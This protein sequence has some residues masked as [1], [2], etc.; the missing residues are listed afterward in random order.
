MILLSEHLRLLVLAGNWQVLRHSFLG[1]LI[2]RALQEGALVVELYLGL[3][4]G[5]WLVILGVVG[6]VES[7]DCIVLN[8]VS[9]LPFVHYLLDWATGVGSFIDHYW[10][11]ASL[12]PNHIITPRWRN[13]IE[14]L[15]FCYEVDL[16]LLLHHGLLLSLTEGSVRDLRAHLSRVEHA[17]SLKLVLICH[18]WR[19][20]NAVWWRL[21]GVWSHSG[22]A[23]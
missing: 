21:A 16:G 9:A 1:G 12:E 11:L 10:H 2:G 8:F 3:R 15:L 4:V 23:L 6:E 19:V 7:S 14:F 22:M 18:I 5:C 17:E 20:V 13:L